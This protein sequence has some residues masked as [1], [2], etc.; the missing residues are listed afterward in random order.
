MHDMCLVYQ[1]M[2]VY[3]EN[4]IDNDRNYH[5]HLSITPHDI[6]NTISFPL[7]INNIDNDHNNH[8]HPSV[9]QH[10]LPSRT[11]TTTTSKNPVIGWKCL[12]LILTTPTTPHNE[13]KAKDPHKTMFNLIPVIVYHFR[14][15]EIGIVPGTRNETDCPEGVGGW[16]IYLDHR[17]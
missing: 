13:T 3:H 12:C 11:A 8:H 17:I 4:N 2:F 14:P 10:Q 5:H 7:S 1:Y 6:S 16:V 9:N 15:I